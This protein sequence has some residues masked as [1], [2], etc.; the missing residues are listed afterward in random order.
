MDTS[1][2]LQQMKDYLVR[3]LE[4]SGEFSRIEPGY[5]F[6]EQGGQPAL[7]EQA[8]RHIYAE[9]KPEFSPTGK[10]LPFL[11]VAHADTM[12]GLLFAEKLAAASNAG[13]YSVPLL[14]R[15]INSH[16]DPSTH[17]PLFRRFLHQEDRTK[18]ARFHKRA[19]A[20]K[21]SLDHY[22]PE[23]RNNFRHLRDIEKDWVPAVLGGVTLY[24]QPP[25]PRLA[26]GVK[27]YSWEE[28][29]FHGQDGFGE[30]REE[31]SVD[32]KEPQERESMELLTLQP[33]LRRMH[34]R[35]VRRQLEKSIL[36]QGRGREKVQFNF[37]DYMRGDF[38]LADVIG[39]PPLEVH[40]DEER[41]IR[42]NMGILEHRQRF[43][44]GNTEGL[45]ERIAIQMDNISE[46]HPLIPYFE[47]LIRRDRAR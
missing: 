30:Y 13:I 36:I 24:Y 2:Q 16:T 15:Y 23:R 5:D 21:Q 32:I 27:R 12:P 29:I 14:Y 38:L 20:R 7:R 44:L 11:I 35:T 1:A 40:G 46:G 34:S 4:Q 9:L 39:L 26:E 10:P 33:I 8:Q 18:G 43:Q 41:L 28:V 47:Q 45:E 42:H 6:K 25:S 3:V 31:T 19:A 17:G 22:D 37:D